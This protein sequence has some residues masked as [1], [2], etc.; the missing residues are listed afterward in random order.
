MLV[1]FFA[2]QDAK[3][4]VMH[5]VGEDEHAAEDEDGEEPG[6]P[7]VKDCE[8][9]EVRMVQGQ[10]GRDESG[11]IQAARL[12]ALVRCCEARRDQCPLMA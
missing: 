6:V 12:L 9:R 4:D 8:D 2:A 10:F 7:E 3:E 1:R 5:D 11:W